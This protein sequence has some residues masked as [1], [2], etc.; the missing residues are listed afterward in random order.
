MFLRAGGG[1]RAGNGKKDRFF[2]RCEVRDGDGMELVGGVEVGEGGF[3]ELVSD[4]ND[5]GDF[6]DCGEFEGLMAAE[7]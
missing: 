1:E 5:G 2:V 7:G 4:G 3:G 6:G